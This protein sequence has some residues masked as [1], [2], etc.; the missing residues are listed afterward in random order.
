[1]NAKTI[2]NSIILNCINKEVDEIVSKVDKEDSMINSD[3]ILN[4]VDKRKKQFDFILENFEKFMEFNNEIIRTSY[5]DHHGEIKNL[6][7]EIKTLDNLLSIRIH[8]R[9]IEYSKKCNDA[10]ISS[11]L[12]DRCFRIKWLLSKVDIDNAV[13]NYKDMQI[14]KK[15]I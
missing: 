14:N 13:N 10:L 12:I 2:V 3:F 8:E 5:G 1:M 7:N 4:H 15:H 6:S 11:L 9:I